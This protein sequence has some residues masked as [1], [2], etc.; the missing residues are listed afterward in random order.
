MRERGRFRSPSNEYQMVEVI[1]KQMK[2]VHL[3][4]ISLPVEMLN[5]DRNRGTKIAD[6]WEKYK[7]HQ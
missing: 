4:S 2:S 3:A 5:F 1:S 7:C 6:D